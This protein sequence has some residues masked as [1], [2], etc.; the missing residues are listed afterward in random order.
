MNPP[1]KPKPETDADPASEA[2]RVAM[3]LL[4]RREHATLELERKLRDRGFDD[5]VI[6]GTVSWLCDKRYLSDRRFAEQFVSQRIGRGSGP[7]KLRAELGQRGLDETAIDEALADA[8]V[9]WLNLA[10]SV[11]RKRFG[12]AL[13]SDYHERMRQARFLQ[14][15]GFATADIRHVLD[16]VDVED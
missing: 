16:G 8:E 9:D 1:R 4:A 14:G 3:G 7:L 2:R 15:R 10:A 5:D 11:R 12:P 6:A 13:P